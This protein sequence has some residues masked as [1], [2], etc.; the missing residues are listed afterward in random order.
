MCL[1]IERDDRARQEIA[2]LKD[3]TE[4]AHKQIPDFLPKIFWILSSFSFIFFIYLIENSKMSQKNIFFF[5][6]YR[7]FRL[8]ICPVNHTQFYS[9][10][11]NHQRL[12]KTFIWYEKFFFFMTMSWKNLLEPSEIVVFGFKMSYIRHKNGSLR[13]APISKLEFFFQDIVWQF[14][15][16]P[17]TSHFLKKNH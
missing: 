1:E 11:W 13:T 4:N 7:N 6:F 8:Q 17:G 14:N 9:C 5:N 10:Y 16:L 15:K 12:L 2:L 3:D